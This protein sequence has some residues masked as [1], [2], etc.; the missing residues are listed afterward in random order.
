MN[1]CR[2]LSVLELGLSFMAVAVAAACGGKSTSPT[3]VGNTGGGG[4][5][6]AATMP[7]VGIHACWFTES[8][9][10]YGEHR[11]D[12]TAGEPMHLDKVSGMETF[13]GTLASG[14]DGV[15]LTGTIGCGEMATACKQTFTVNLT[16][17]DD[18]WSGQVRPVEEWW[19]KGA[20]FSITHQ[21]GY[22]GDSY[23]GDTYG[24]E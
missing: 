6:A 11:C 4:E 19:L 16:R 15:V 17:T 10:P 24:G 5:P 22:G 13:E 7:S 1:N 14:A 21:A 9:Q 8:G 23:G 20:T 12:V 18:V 2:R 3:G